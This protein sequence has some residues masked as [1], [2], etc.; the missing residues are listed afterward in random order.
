[1]HDN[2]RNL[3]SAGHLS[4]YILIGIVLI[5][6]VLFMLIAYAEAAGQIQI[7]VEGVEGEMKK[8]VL[9]YLSIE[10][11][12]DYPD[13]T[14]NLVKKLH[15]QAPEEC[16]LALQ[17]FGYYN[18]V[19]HAEL[20]RDGAVW[21]ARY[22]IEQGSPVLIDTIDLSIK[23]EGSEDKR[24]ISLREKLP[25]KKGEVLVH[26]N[27]AEAKRMLLDTAMRYGYVLAEMTA[28]KV[29][30]HPEKNSAAITLHFDTGPQHYFGSV[31]FVQDAF[32]QE[33]L[34]RL[35]PFKRR[36]PYML[37]KILMLQN[38]LN[39]VDYFDSVQV[40]PLM[41]RA[42]DLEV[43]IEV[44]LI[45]RK[46]HKYTFGLGYGTD[47]GVRGSAGWEN[48]RVT[49]NGHRFKTLL[50]LSEVRSGITGEYQVP[51][52][53]PRTE[54]LVFTAGWHKETT[55]TSESERYLGGVRYNHMR[56]S[57]KESVYISYEQEKYDIGDESGRSDLL[58]PGISWTRISADNPVM[59]RRGSRLFLD[60]RGAHDALLSDTSFMQA[61][62]QVKF[63]RGVTKLSR[64]IIRAEGGTSIMDAFSELPPSVR[65]FT[66][67]DNSVRGYTYNSL[68]PED[69][70]GNVIGGRY[71]LAGSV[72][73]EHRIKDK[74][75]AA[76]FYDAG[77]AMDDVS[78]PL[79]KSAG[80]GIRWGSPVGPIRLDI[81][82]PEDDPD[83]SWRIHF[84]LGPDL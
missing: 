43:P 12:K 53:K 19:I 17:P 63:I 59:A 4:I 49:K 56:S 71:L 30:V 13:L 54:N 24:F 9:A 5:S 31:E 33:F 68:G 77:N 39:D 76:V 79:R 25:L 34:S 47:T 52:R 82:F 36:E 57:W 70:E 84:I 28:A 20:T 26:T 72:E 65:F 64:M 42:E 8:N 51:L 40:T 67:G 37:S 60:I 7:V 80:F 1:M 29:A 45:P 6:V 35:V 78:D 10:R 2:A 38:T 41:D 21:R 3:R 74:W 83:T 23:G 73:F 16:R 27:Y 75:S 69:D 58:I 15:K 62:M 61:R 11:Q 22:R 55:D 81:A 44:S 18:P 50:R 14:A 46:K 48:R 32:N 66:G